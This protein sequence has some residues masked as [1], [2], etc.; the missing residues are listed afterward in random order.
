MPRTPSNNPSLWLHGYSTCLKPMPV[1]YMMQ[2]R[3]IDGLIAPTIATATTSSAPT[4]GATKPR[5]N[6]LANPT[7]PT[8]RRQLYNDLISP[9]IVTR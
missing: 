3:S 8:A 7:A 9:R 2:Q 5:V 4:A 6:N 1:M